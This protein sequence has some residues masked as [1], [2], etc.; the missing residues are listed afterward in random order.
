ML[1][2]ALP[3]ENIII[4]KK[5]KKKATTKILFILGKKNEAILT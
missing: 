1:L 2:N 4:F 5:K 3:R